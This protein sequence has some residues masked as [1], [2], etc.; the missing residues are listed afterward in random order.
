MFKYAVFHGFSCLPL[1]SEQFRPKIHIIPVTQADTKLVILLDFLQ[2]KCATLARQQMGTAA[3]FLSLIE[4]SSITTARHETLERSGAPWRKIMWQAVGDFV[5]GPILKIFAFLFLA[6][7]YSSAVRVNNAV[8]LAALNT[9]SGRLG[10]N[11]CSENLWIL[12]DIIPQ[13]RHFII[14]G[15]RNAQ[16]MP[17]SSALLH[18]RA[19]QNTEVYGRSN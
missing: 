14:F 3:C 5:V 7:H 16:N 4:A 15:Q 17:L 8:G 6:I 19:G 10:V 2:T 12:S 1:I 11:I 9:L 18:C 13:L